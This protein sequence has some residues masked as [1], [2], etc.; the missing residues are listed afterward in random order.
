MKTKK[1]PARA[2]MTRGA[3]ARIYFIDRQ[4]A[5]LKYPNVPSL[6]EEYLAEKGEEG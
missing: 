3:L 6:V 4:I 2:S 5:S 1:K